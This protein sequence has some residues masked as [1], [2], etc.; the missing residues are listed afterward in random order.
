MNGLPE[1]RGPRTSPRR[2][3]LGSSSSNTP[4]IDQP[5]AP[6]LADDAG[7]DDWT[8]FRAR[9]HLSSRKRLA[10][11]GE[12]YDSAAFVSVRLK[13]DPGLPATILRAPVYGEW[14]T[15]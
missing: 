6:S 4:S 10:F 9:P 7:E 8:Y 5:Q 3:L 15:A 13:R 1:M 12:G 14:G 11:E 2:D